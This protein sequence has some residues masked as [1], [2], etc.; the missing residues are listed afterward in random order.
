MEERKASPML[1]AFVMIASSIIG[2]VGA[3]AGQAIGVLPDFLKS[4]AKT[5]NVPYPT[6]TPYPTH[7]P[8]ST[9]TLAYTPEPIATIP[10]SP[11]PSSIPQP[12]DT[13]QPTPIPI[14]S[15]PI[16][17]RDDFSNPNRGWAFT[18]SSKNMNYQ[19]GMLQIITSSQLGDSGI[20]YPGM[21]FKDFV[22]EVD[23]Q[24][25]SDT[26]SIR[27]GVTFRGG[28]AYPFYKYYLFRVGSDGICDFLQRW[29]A[30]G[31]Y[32]SVLIPPIFSDAVNHFGEV[33]RIHIEAVGG[34][35]RFFV[36]DQFVAEHEAID[37]QNT[38]DDDLSSGD[39]GLYVF[40]PNEADGQVGFDNLIVGSLKE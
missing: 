1:W 26:P 28:Y 3:M 38:H 34:H 19:S 37:Y 8:Y 5:T 39:I 32:K 2:C 6:Y 18:G 35:F 23:A 22:L 21:Q 16:L 9:L 29:H 24:N 14:S 4:Q 36:N 25:L 20:A 33:N 11:M 13:P 30:G 17:F 15:V 10:A 27:I 7:T 40:N 12:T 31:G